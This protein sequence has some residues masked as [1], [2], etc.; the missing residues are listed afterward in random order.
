[1]TRLLGASAAVMENP[2]LTGQIADSHAVRALARSNVRHD[3]HP[4]DQQLQQLV[5]QGIERS[6]Q[7]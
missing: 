2:L 5:I 6:A 3:V 1:M 4:P 7:L